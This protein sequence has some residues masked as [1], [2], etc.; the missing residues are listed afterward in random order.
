[1]LSEHLDTTYTIVWTLAVANVVGAIACLAPSTFIAK[2]SLIRATRLAPFLF[3]V[4]VLGAFQSTTSWGDIVAFLMIGFLGW[5]MRTLKIPRPPF[6][7]GFVLAANAERYLWISFSRYGWHWL[8]RPGVIV[9]G[10]VIVL[11]T[12]GGIRMRRNTRGVVDDDT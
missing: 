5:V 1:M 7:I 6:L 4:L 2:L 9:I 11:L 10:L 12:L 3:V 8:L